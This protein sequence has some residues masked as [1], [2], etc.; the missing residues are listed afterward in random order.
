MKQL[1]TLVC[2]LT[3]ALPG[4]QA[5]NQNYWQQKVD[6]TMDVDVDAKNHQYAGKQ[7]LVYTNNSP[8]VLN[9][10]YY[11]LYFNAFQP[12]SMMDNRSRTI[13]DPDRRVG[14]RISHLDESEIGYEK[15]NSLTQDGKAVKYEVDGTILVVELNKPIKPG[16]KTT[17]K[18]E[19]DAQVPL[20]IRRSGWNNKAGVELS[21]AQWYPKLAHYDFQGWHPDPYIGREFYGTFGDFDVKISIDKEYV[22]GGTGIIQNP[23]EIGYGY[24]KE[25][26]KVKR[27][28]GEKLTWHFK[29]KNVLDFFWGADPDYVH[30]IVQVPN[31]PKVHL[32]HQKKVDESASDEQNEKYA[33]NWEQLPEFT[34]KAI[35]Y[36]NEHFGE[37][38]YPQ[39]SVI[40]GGDGG[41]EYPMGTFIT[42]AR[43]LGSLVG[44]TVHEMFHSWY[45][46]VIAT[47]E[48]LLPWMDE[49]F[50]SFASAETMAHLFNQNGDP[51]SG[52]YR[53]YNYIVESGKEEPLT[54]HSDHYNTN[55]AYSVA[56]YSKGAIFLNQLSYIIGND[57]FR[58]GML[59]Y[60]KE[61]KLKN[62]TALDFINVMEKESGMILDWY[63]EYFVQ[64]TKTIDYGITAVVGDESKTTVK[65]DRIGL[66]PMP[67]D[68]VVEYNDGSS[69]LFYIPL[70]LMRGEKPA[71]NDMKRTIL[72]D[73]VWVKTSY[74]FTIDKPASSIKSVTIDPSHRM[75][76][77][78][79][80]NN[81]F[82]VSEMLSN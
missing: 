20:Q 25:G 35:Q 41:M 26:A 68:V 50:T 4:V 17:F 27:P 52:S 80:E 14:D 10:V 75:A 36:A 65:L 39:F 62:P 2:I 67:L 63:Y 42:G 29:A 19:W 81:T 28:K 5:Q 74:N 30:T 9:R 73:W 22:L 18:M 23:N 34:V 54:T 79:Q 16:A 31:G 15:I 45:Q 77:I 46:N 21:M 70:R 32:L 49:G 53:S 55:A 38:P 56:A 47:N 33:K 1:L 3:F 78:D 8:D 69:E 82:N 48:S 43:S 40:Q 72:E 6:Y 12:G 76:D 60:H 13:V 61:W 58:R 57:T 11:H 59:R 37:Y 24:E 66:M 71:E 7:T 51:Q 64:T 44:V